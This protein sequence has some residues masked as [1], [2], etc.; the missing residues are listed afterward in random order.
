MG[1]TIHYE[2]R[3][4]GT[5]DDTAA[6]DMLERLR[7]HALTLGADGVSDICTLS[8][9]DLCS[10]RDEDVWTFERLIQFV[11]EC[12]WESQDDAREPV[13]PTAAVGAAAFL[14]KPGNE[15]ESAVF[16]LV[17]PRPGAI[18]NWGYEEDIRNWC[19][20]SFCKTQYAANVSDEHFLRCHL[21]VVEILDEAKR[22]GFTVTVHDEGLYWDTRST[23]S[24]LAELRRSN[25]IIARFAGALHD[26]NPE[27]DLQAPIFEH[28][29]FERL[30]TEPVCRRRRD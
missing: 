30:E 6:L 26:A 27:L 25:Q 3:L 13:D 10:D 21:M 2:L 8:G 28:P 19:W 22:L 1:L 18:A 9:A 14:V 23:D 15:S 4:P 12:L 20:Q 11:A 24:L 16:G 7:A 5:L 29:D 17:R